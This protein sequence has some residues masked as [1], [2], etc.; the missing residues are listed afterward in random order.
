M[1]NA[2][3]TAPIFSNEVLE[4]RQPGAA[5]N[6]LNPNEMQLE[7]GLILV[8]DTPQPVDRSTIEVIAAALAS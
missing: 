6:S 7:P 2:A 5:L 8:R 4:R 3:P 1:Q